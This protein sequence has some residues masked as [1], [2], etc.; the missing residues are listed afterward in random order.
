MELETTEVEKDLGIM[1][2]ADGRCSAQVEAAVNR[3][4]WI[5]GRIRKTFRFFN[6]K[7]FKKLYPT[8]VRPH[9]EFA[10]SVWNTMTK[11]EIKKIE[12]VQRR[13]TGMVLELRGLEYEERLR[14]LGYTNL[15]LR[16]KRGDL[17]QLYKVSKGLEEV[18]LGVNM[19]R[20]IGGRSHTH[21]IVREDCRNCNLRGRFLPNRTATTWNLLP[22]SVVDA[23]TVNGFKSGLDALIVSGNLRRSVYQV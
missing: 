9:L 21:Q 6:I 12:S 3:A 11:K 17:I 13:A 20:G 8:F 1:I 16:R 22:P 19:G 5:L 15:E 18:D 10:S 4:S 23:V 14:R 2:T 7:L